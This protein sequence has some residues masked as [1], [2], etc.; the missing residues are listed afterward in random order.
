MAFFLTESRDDNNLTIITLWEKQEQ[1]SLNPSAFD[2]CAI[3]S[4]MI[5]LL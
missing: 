5:K 1:M 4:R 3:D 2:P